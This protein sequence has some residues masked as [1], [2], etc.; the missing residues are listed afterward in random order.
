MTTFDINGQTVSVHSPDDT[1][2]LWAIRDEL[3]SFRLF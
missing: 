1:P 3:D 2:L